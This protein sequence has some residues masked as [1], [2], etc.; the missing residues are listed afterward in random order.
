M[1]LRK[2]R[3]ENPLNRL[4]VP[5]QTSKFE[6]RLLIFCV[7]LLCFTGVLLISKFLLLGNSIRLDES[8]S[9]WQTS[10][11]IT[12]TLKVVAQDVHV[13]L[14]HLILHFWQFYLGPNIVTARLLSMIFFLATIP[15]VYLIA[16]RI[17]S[18]N[19]S[20]LAVTLFSFSPFLNWYANEARMYTL[21][22]FVSALSQYF[23]LRVI[24]EKG[25]KG[26]LWY[27]ISALIGVYTHYFFVFNLLTQGIFFLLNRK[28][29]APHT[30][31]KFI[32]LAVG[33]AI[34]LAPWMV[35]FVSLGSASNTTPNLSAPSSVDLFNAFSQFSFGFQTDAANTILVSSW[36]LLVAVALLAV[37]RGQRVTL[38]VGY[39]LAAALVPVM[40]AFALSFLVAPFFVS[41]YMV[42]CVAPLVIVGVWFISNYGRY[43]SKAVTALLIVVISLASLQ[44]YASSATPVKEE[45]RAAA[46]LISRNARSQDVVVLSA[47]F[48][49]YPFDYYYD[50]PARISTLPIWNRSMPGPV[51]AFDP[52]KLPAEASQIKKNHQYVYLLLSYDQGYQEQVF[53]YFERT[54]PRVKSVK[55][56]DDVS[57]YVYQ[58]G[59][60][61]VPPIN[62]IDPSR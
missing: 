8:Q 58:V 41:R 34:A 53:Q 26:W 55:F 51:P 30:L 39:M 23:F 29:F 49:I 60:Y 1:P 36:P 56:S 3:S 18:V 9:L 5:A 16:R 6:T 62:Q 7:F 10:H 27:S 13:P 15:L 40:L 48:T 33:L 25:K 45:Y 47:P 12:G 54:S 37:K 31:K 57:L 52:A 61:T 50:G 32:A 43:L 14:Y 42:S 28:N 17:L 11:S 59:Y 19:W 20:L 46:E 38:P 24:R 21:L 44:Q 22:L 4:I 35:Y 2:K